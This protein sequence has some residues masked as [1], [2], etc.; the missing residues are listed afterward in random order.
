M[1]HDPAP[2]QPGVSARLPALAAA[3]RDIAPLLRLMS[4]PDRLAILC[5]LADG[6]HSVAQIQTALGLRQP[7]LSQQLSELREAGLV[8]VRRE[9]RTAHYALADARSQALLAALESALTPPGAPPPPRTAGAGAGAALRAGPDDQ[10][11]HFAR[12]E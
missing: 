6:E 11:A 10:S 12:L 1:V 9:S 4:N 2:G 3:V 8:E 7:G 5:L